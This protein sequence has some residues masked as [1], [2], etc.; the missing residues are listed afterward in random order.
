MRWRSGRLAS[1]PRRE[2]VGE[3]SALHQEHIAW[4]RQ[5]PLFL[6]LDG[7]RV[8]HACWH[9]PSMAAL[10]PY[11]DN[12]NCILPSAWPALTRTQGAGFE[13]LET[14]LKG[15]EIALPAGYDFL[16]KDGH[17]RRRIRTRWWEMEGLTYRDLAMVPAEAIETIPHMPIPDDVLPGYDS[18]KPLFVGHYWLTGTPAPLNQQIACLDYSIAAERLSGD[19]APKLCAYRWQGETVLT[20]EHMVW[21]DAPFA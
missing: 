11:L 12:Q 1:R 3:G 21:V 9:P 20:S 5:L 7:F 19:D 2:Q 17:P 10:Q 13:A 8:V 14:L 6:E 18:D 15:L 16:D 4:F